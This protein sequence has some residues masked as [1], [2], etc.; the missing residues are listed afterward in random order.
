MAGALYVQRAGDLLFRAAVPREGRRR[1]IFGGQLMA[2]ALLACG[3][4]VAAGLDPHL[5][6]ARFL[7]P[8]DPD[9]DVDYYIGPFTDRGSFAHRRV[10]ARQGRTQILDLTASFHR[11]EEGPEYQFPPPAEGDPL[12]LPTFGDLAAGGSDKSARQWWARLSQ[13]LP[14]Q[15]RA[16]GVPGRWL[17]APGGEAGPRQQ[18][19]FL[20]NDELGEESLVHA[21]AAAYASDLF[22]LT[23]AMMP[24]GLRHDDDDVLAVTLNHTMWFHRA[25]RTD[26]WWRYDQEGSWSGAGRLLCRG[27]MFDRSGRLVATAMQEGLLRVGKQGLCAGERRLAG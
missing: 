8:G 15:V 10:M 11:A 21:A 16:A 4:T 13:W 27:Q 24:H 7:R 19:W 12:D 3:R 18:V 25:F 26:E 5:L 17:L 14:V 1:R 9:Q 22:L 2:Q 20:S 6:H 23:A